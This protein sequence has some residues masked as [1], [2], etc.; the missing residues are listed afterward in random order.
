MAYTSSRLL[1]VAAVCA[2]AATCCYASAAPTHTLSAARAQRRVLSAPPSEFCNG[3]NRTDCGYVGINQQICQSRGCCWSPV[4]EIVTHDGTQVSSQPRYGGIPW[5]FF[6]SPPSPSCSTS[7]QCSGHGA[8]AAG[9]GTCTCSSGYTTCAAAP[10]A[11]ECAVDTQTDPADCGACGQ[12]CPTGTGVASST[13]SLGK[14]VT[15]CSTGYKL[16]FGECIQ[17]TTCTWRA[18]LCVHVALTV[19]PPSSLQVLAMLPSAPRMYRP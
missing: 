8:C 5:C 16:C 4:N 9:N 15:Q 6:K 1:V 12:S 10:T 11:E 3:G 17:G 13:C 18:S 14:C 19:T 7:P 2:L